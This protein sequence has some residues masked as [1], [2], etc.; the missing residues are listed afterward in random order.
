MWEAT[1]S[2][3]VSTENETSKTSQGAEDTGQEWEKLYNYNYLKKTI[4]YQLINRDK[5]I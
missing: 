3:L 1:V 5:L 2:R 4:T